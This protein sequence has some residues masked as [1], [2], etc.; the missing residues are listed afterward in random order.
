MKVKKMPVAAILLAITIVVYIVA[1]LLFSYTTKPEVDKGEF[2]FSITYE[3]KGKIKTVSGV[4]ECE[5]FDSGTVAGDHM[6]DWSE[7]LKYENPE[8][9]EEPHVIDQN[10]EE[11]MILTM[12]P[13][14]RA[15]YFMGD[16]LY[17][18][19][20]EENG[21]EGP[22]PYVEYCD[23]KN[24][25]FSNSENR[26]EVLASIGF[27]IIDFTYAE[28]IENS[29]SFSGIRFEAD[30]IGIFFLIML[31]FFVLCLIFVHKDNEYQYRGIDKAGIILNFIVGVVAVPFIFF[32]CMLFG[33]VES[34]VE[35]INQIVYSTPPIAMLCLA[36]SVV[37][38]RKGFSK[39]GFLIQFG[40]ILLFIFEF[41]LEAVL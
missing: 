29:F 12:V 16:P 41:G 7:E 10:D 18:D 22:Q 9:I 30:N 5:Y 20:Y 15:G 38:R 26:D 3:Y 21:F 13:D 19:V 28:P 17:K 35:I 2:A 37:F 23:Y 14:M 31:A 4:L 33:I 39:I 6:R 32:F 8:N 36:L 34:D 24:E 27:K 25:I 1:A 11:Q 40:G